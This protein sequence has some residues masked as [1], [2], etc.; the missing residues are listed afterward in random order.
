MFVEV[1]CC[2]G[3]VF[4]ALAVAIQP[5]PCWILR[6]YGLEPEEYFPVQFMQLLVELFV[7]F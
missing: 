2:C 4:L 6:P 3:W 5:G 1:Y 7:L